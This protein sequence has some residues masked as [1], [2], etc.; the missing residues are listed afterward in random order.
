M[1]I[2][3]SCIGINDLSRQ[4]TNW[5]QLIIE[6]S[7]DHDL[8]LLGTEEESKYY[9]EHIGI[10]KGIKDLQGLTTVKES[11]EEIKESDLFIGG[12][13]GLMHV[14]VMS[15]IPTI[16]IFQKNDHFFRTSHLNKR[17]VIAMFRPSVRE[18]VDIVND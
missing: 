1:V 15:E 14:A 6:L 12:E 8:I 13:T 10:Y 3:I 9:R 5:K 16:C 11:I 18:V 2:T 7:K 17:N 4:W